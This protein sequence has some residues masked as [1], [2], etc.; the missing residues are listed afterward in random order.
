MAEFVNDPSKA[1]DTAAIHPGPQ[2][3]IGHARACPDTPNCVTSPDLSTVTP[4]EFPP[5]LSL[6]L[7][8]LKRLVRAPLHSQGRLN[9]KAKG[10]PLQSPET[11]AGT[12]PQ[13]AGAL[14]EIGGMTVVR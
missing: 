9:I 2:N 8:H 7:F 10:K 12:P 5:P 6:V 11:M 14:A 13:G 4:S 3:T 1:E